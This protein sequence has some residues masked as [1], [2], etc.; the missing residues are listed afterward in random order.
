MVLFFCVYM[1]KGQEKVI[2]DDVLKPNKIYIEDQNV[3]ISEE[4]VIKVFSLTNGK[5]LYQ[6]TKK[7][8]GPNE[9]KYSPALTFLPE[10]IVATGRGKVIFYQRDG[11]II[12]EKRVPLNIQMFPVKYNY[13]GSMRIM[14]EKLK[15]ITKKDAIY[16]ADFQKLIEV[17]TRVPES[18]VV[19]ATGGKTARQNYYMIPNGNGFITDGR[20]ICLYDSKRGF[21]IEIYNYEGK[22]I[23]T[24]NKG[25][26]KVKVSRAYKI[27]E[28]A[29]L[30]K[31]KDWEQMKKLFNF[32]FPE[33]FPAFRR[34][35]INRSLLYV[36]TATLVSKEQALT[37][38]DF[39]GK[40]LH[41]STIPKLRCR[42][43]QKGK[44]YYFKESEDEKWAL[45][46]NKLL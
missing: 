29:V 23:S 25:Y 4:G 12:D 3:Y 21:Y 11:I 10:Q 8:A 17:N 43:F 16:N 6:L 19:F 33:H 2:F 31:N 35:F 18:V 37:I 1:V 32:V 20:D 38:M 5:K 9:F 13:I 28:M 39:T 14:D 42:Y 26:P 27:R 41:Q 40:V 34:V 22:K 7:G 24:I 15:R 46:I 44:F 36:L 30:K 45:H